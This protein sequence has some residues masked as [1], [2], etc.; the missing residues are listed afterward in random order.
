MQP[1]LPSSRCFTTLTKRHFSAFSTPANSGLRAS[2]TWT[3]PKSSTSDST[4]RAAC[5]R[6]R[7]S[8]AGASARAFCREL[9][10]DGEREKIKELIAFYSVSFGLRDVDQ[11]WMDYADQGRGVSLGLAPEFFG[12]H[13]SKTRTI[14]NRRR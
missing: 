2:T 8:G 12:P 13:L 6:K 3:I 5:S 11:Q 1:M 4:W 9:G 14:R 10:E 7:R